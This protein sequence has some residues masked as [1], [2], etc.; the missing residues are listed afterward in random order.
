MVMSGGEFRA[1][2][3]K[4]P[5]GRVLLE[6]LASPLAAQDR[7]REHEPAVSLGDRGD[8]VGAGCEVGDVAASLGL[9]IAGTACRGRQ[10]AEQVLRAPAAWIW[11][12]VLRACS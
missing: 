5:H 1:A 2:P 6:I 12:A 10:F 11:M 8:L 4:I 9:E 3:A 7:R